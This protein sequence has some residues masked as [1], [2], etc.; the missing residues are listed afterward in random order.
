[1]KPQGAGWRRY[2]KNTSL[3]A[4]LGD[5]RLI[6]L[7]RRWLKAS[8]LEDGGPRANEEGTPQGGSISVLLRTMATGPTDSTPAMNRITA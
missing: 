1:M 6:S 7:I 3:A 5:P 8:I 2:I 4:F